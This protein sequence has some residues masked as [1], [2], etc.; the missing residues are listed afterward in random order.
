[1]GIL[2][3]L[4]RAARWIGRQIWRTKG[5]WGPALVLG[6][7]GF[8][9]AG[10]LGLGLA[11]PLAAALGGAGG[12]ALGLSM[13]MRRKTGQ[14]RERAALQAQ[15]ANNS[16]KQAQ[17][18]EPDPRL[19]EPKQPK[20]LEESQRFRE[21]QQWSRWTRA[22]QST[23]PDSRQNPWPENS[24]TDTDADRSRSVPPTPTPRHSADIAGM[25]P[26]G[27]PTDRESRPRGD[28]NT[29]RPREESR[30]R[31]RPRSRGK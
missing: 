11:L 3:A 17:L 16:S 27:F 31:S 26:N 2:R 12:A 13:G 21:F 24:R 5:I 19:K 28:S 15:E 30:E 18:P 9:L 7:V 10:P 23:A 6:A 8:A 14:L 25:M 29:G 22:S 20:D 4:G 1:V